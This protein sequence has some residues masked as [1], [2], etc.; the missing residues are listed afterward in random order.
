MRTRSRVAR[1]DRLFSVV[2]LGGLLFRGDLVVAT[3][4]TTAPLVVTDPLAPR[5]SA[6]SLE[7]FDSCPA[8][9]RW[10]VDHAVKQVGPYGWNGPVLYGAVDDVAGSVAPMAAAAPG[11]AE[12]STDARA[13]SGTGTNTQEADVDEPD[14]AKTDGRRVVRLVD[15]R[16]VVITDVTG[17]QPREVGRVSLPTDLY[18]GELLLAGDH[19]LVSQTVGQW[20][21]GG[22][23]P[24]DAP[25]TADG[26]G[27]GRLVG[28]QGGTRIGDNEIKDPAAPRVVHDD[29]YTGQQVSM[30][31]YG[32]TVRLVTTTT[33]PQLA[34]AT[35]EGRGSQQ[36][37]E[38][39]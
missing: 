17:A 26:V 16:T 28:P 25:A 10:Y 15:Q 4:A 39:E 22:P 36:L 13:S 11:A 31:L 6:D 9:L 34:W 32:S 27:S 5:A 30:R 23:M 19:V 29:S 37:S 8:L 33:G 35:P 7:R 24:M 20:Y 18:G 2:T 14:I 3:V 38:A 1:G 21:R 12:K